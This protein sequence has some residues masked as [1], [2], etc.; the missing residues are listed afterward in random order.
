MIRC[1][2]CRQTSDR[3]SPTAACMRCEQNVEA[4]LIALGGPAGLYASVLAM[5]SEAMEV[6]RVGSRAER[7]SARVEA[8]MPLSTAALSL[9]SHGGAVTILRMWV[10]VWRQDPSR[11]APPVVWQGDQIAQLTVALDILLARLSWA[12]E[13]RADFGEFRRDVERIVNECRRILDPTD[14][15]AQPVSRLQVGRCPGRDDQPCGQPLEVR[16]GATA[17]R[18]PKCASVW[19]RGQWSK[20]AAAI[21][22]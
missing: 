15:D 13:E 2:I 1:P 22:R 6:V 9:T 7:G 20:L 12:A 4:E 17:I 11:P 19:P 18:C 16:L 14:P 21:G 8:P 10:D 3:E 5:G